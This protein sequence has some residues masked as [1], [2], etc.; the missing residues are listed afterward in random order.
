M[1]TL[2][3]AAARALAIFETFAQEKRELSNSELA[4]LLGLADSSCLDLVY[5][6]HQ[7]GY[8][9]R[10]EQTRRY[11]PTAQLMTVAQQIGAE[12]PI[13]SGTLEALDY[14]AEETGETAY[15]GHMDGAAVKVVALK[16]GRY[17]LRHLLTINQRVALHASAMGKALLGMLSPEEAT[18]LLTLRPLRKLTAATVVE[19]AKILNEV[20]FG[21]HRGWYETHSEGEPGSDAYAISGMLGRVPI[22]ISISGPNDRFHNNVETYVQVLLTVGERVFGTKHPRPEQ[23]DLLND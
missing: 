20:E 9:T 2:V 13:V 18:R 1:P 16:E 21:R 11:Y 7:L 14:L 19:P 3:S 22:A 8:L 23:A 17:R 10:N 4:R 6:L 15:V 12:D 5:T